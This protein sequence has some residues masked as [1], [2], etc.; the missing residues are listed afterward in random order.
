MTALNDQ[1]RCEVIATDRLEY[2]PRASS[3]TVT[4]G[5]LVA[6]PLDPVDRR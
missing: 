6:V 4:I 1:W 2:S 3:A 5:G